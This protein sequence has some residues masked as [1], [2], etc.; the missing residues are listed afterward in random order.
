LKIIPHSLRLLIVIILIIGV[1]IK[2]FSQSYT[3]SGYVNDSTSGEAL[4][5]ATIATKDHLKGTTS[6]EYGF[7]SLTLPT[8]PV[9]INFS[10]SGYQ[11]QIK[12]FYLQSDTTLPVFL[13]ILQLNEVEIVAEEVG[14]T[15]NEIQTGVVEIPVQ[16]IKLLPALLGEV[17]VVKALQLMPGVSGGNEG[18]AGLYVRGGGPDQNLILLDGVPLYY[19]NHLGGFFSIF[20]ANALSQVKLYKGGFPAR[21]GGRLSSVLDIRMKEGNRNKF[22]GEGSIGLISSNIS[23]QGP[24]RKGKS[25][26]IISGRRTYA[27]LF[28]RPITRIMSEGEL[29]VG[30]HFYD[31]NGKIN[32]RFSDRDQLYI[33]FYL[34]QDKFSG[35]GEVN[36]PT[37]QNTYRLNLGWGN[38]LGVIRWNHIWGSKL[39]SNFS[40]NFT[41]YQLQ[42]RF[43]GEATEISSDTTLST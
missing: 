33:S 18:D 39:F 31:L 27:D 40:A 16:Q 34:G 17:D 28:S 38:R 2:I 5:N 23:L 14:G 35:R 29:A 11:K 13:D 41:R 3:I 25:S 9:Q 21:Y 26:F 30:Y 36:E 43:E 15:I 7:Y 22:E 20:N 6:N 24:I 32:H 10:Y 8:G 4:I 19:V 37:Y 12:Q 42:N 1:S